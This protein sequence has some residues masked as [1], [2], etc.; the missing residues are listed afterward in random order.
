MGS[1]NSA[2]CVRTSAGTARV[3]IVSVPSFLWVKRS[4]TIRDF[5]LLY[6]D[7]ATSEQIPW[8]QA[9]IDSLLEKVQQLEQRAHLSWVS[10]KERQNYTVDICF[11][12]NGRPL[13]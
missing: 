12:D 3:R 7:L 9:H 4:E 6:R 13:P 2:P 10:E 8:A 1:D 11:P 5:L